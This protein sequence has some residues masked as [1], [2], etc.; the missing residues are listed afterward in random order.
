MI[1]KDRENGAEILD[2]RLLAARKSGV[3][4]D[5]KGLY[6]E[7]YFKDLSF[8]LAKQ[9]K[10][11]IEKLKKMKVPLDDEHTKEEKAFL[12]KIGMSTKTEE[13]MRERRY[14]QNLAIDQAIK[15]IK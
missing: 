7:F 12:K 11:I 13:F 8:L 4:S 10:E 15:S 14:G 1:K 5:K 9:K 3:K 6:A 2:E